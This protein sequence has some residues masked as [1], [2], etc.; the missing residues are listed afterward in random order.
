MNRYRQPTNPPHDD[1]SIQDGDTG[2]VGVNSFDTMDNLQPGQVQAAV[3]M[4][5]TTMNATT[6]GGFVCLPS[7]GNAPFAAGTGWVAQTSAANKNWTAVA[8]G[9]SRFVAVSILGSGSNDVMYSADAVTWT[10]VSSGIGGDWTNVIFANGMFV[11]IAESGSSGFRVMTSSNGASWTAQ[12]TPANSIWL[13]LTYGNGTFVAV[14][15]DGGSQQAMSSP[16]AVT[17]TRRNTDATAQNEW[18]SVTYGNGLFVAVAFS[19]AG[20]RVMTSPNGVTWTAGASAANN[21]WESVVYGGNS[22]VAVS[23]SGGTSSAMTS[24]DGLTWTLHTTPGSSWFGLAYGNAQFMAVGNAGVANQAAMTSPDGITWTSSTAPNTNQWY[25]ITNGAMT[26]V[27]VAQTGTGNRVMSLGT[28]S[29]VWASGIYSDPNDA[30]SQWV[31]LAG[32]SQVGFFAFGRTGRI[33][34]YD[35]GLT[36]SEQSTIVQ[37]NNQVFLFRGADQVP[38]SWTGDWGDKFELAPTPPPAPDFIVIPNSNQATFCQNR[39][40]V[41]DGKDNL[42]ASDILDFTTFNQLTSEFGLSTGSSDFLVTT[43]PFGP[44]NLVVFK[45]KSIFAL[46]NVNSDLTT[47]TSYEITRQVGC[48]GI[49]AVTSVGSDLVYASDRN[50]NLISLTDTN[51][52]LQHETQPLSRNIKSIIARINWQVAYKISM[53]YWDNKLFVALPLDNSTTCSSVVVF[54]FVTG[55]WF[56]EWNFASSIGMAIQGWATVSYLGAVRLHCITED[57]RIFVTNEGQNDISGTIVAEISSSV[58]TRAYSSDD[59]NRFGRRLYIDIATNRPNFSVESFVEGANESTKELT[60]QT[61]SRAN[62]WLF[63]DTPYVLTNANNDYNRAFRQD[64]STGP[65]NVQCGT[66]FQPEMMQYLRFPI[67]TRRNGRLQWMEVD[68]TTGHI[69][70]GGAGFESRAGYRGNLV[71]VG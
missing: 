58:T 14:S 31:M 13:G 4:D 44:T 51:N 36:V 71:Q 55:Q 70:I 6:R 21:S 47:T 48:I 64:Y 46:T 52:A 20:N 17:W 60:N 29:N 19:G 39:L 42:P 16:D 63:N 9:N 59:M 32:S 22:F 3:N 57:G 1:P 45:N 25:A 23:S 34:Q 53:S 69:V 43:Y 68:N 62:S 18:S 50:I 11:A 54:N 30:G 35:T 8:Y 67:I 56:G 2:F 66:G 33:V 37:C 40:W 28:S 7:L 27:A 5:F 65:N 12:A 15:S 49:N 41:I 10:L 24:P 38:L 26:F 61:Y